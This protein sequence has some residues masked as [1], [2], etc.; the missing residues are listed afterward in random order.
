MT[1]N[2]VAIITGATSGMGLVTLKTLA[3][4]GF[5][6][7]MPVRNNEKGI[8]IRNQIVQS[9]KNENVFV[10]NC[11]LASLKSIEEFVKQFKER[12]NRLDV[13]INNA[14]F[15]EQKRSES[16]N[17][18]E[19]TFAVNHLAPFLLTNLLI[20]I[21]KSTDNA[22]IINVSSM[23][24]KS[25]NINFEDIEGK[26]KYSGFKAYSQSKLANILFTKSLAHRLKGSNVTANCLH[27]GMVKTGFFM[28]VKE[29]WRSLVHLF[30]ITPEKGAETIIY[31][32][33]DPEPA[34]ITGEYFFKK[35]VA[36]SSKASKNMKTAE[37]L[38]QLSEQYVK[39]IIINQ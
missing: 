18:I 19:L 20:D 27:P 38:W 10:M 9:S 32:A 23:A 29:P 39:P 12:F 16:T 4:Q 8:S 2:K 22:R 28:N 25:A 6:L 35:K 15:W 34:S 33:S 13:L 14:G 30:A 7:I 37:K 3:L 21:L 5:T 17:K 31:L 11:D 36:N 26:Q 24:H 1:N